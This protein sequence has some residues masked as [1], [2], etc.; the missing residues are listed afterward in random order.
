[1]IE[2]DKMNIKEQTFL[3]DRQTY[4]SR[5]SNIELLKVLAILLIIIFHFNQT[6]TTSETESLAFTINI[7][8]LAETRPGYAYVLTLF[9]SFGKIKIFL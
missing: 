8:Q 7:T 5:D 6:L 2:V 1:M 9:Q 3:T 4:I